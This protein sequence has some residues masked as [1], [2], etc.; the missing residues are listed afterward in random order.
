MIHISER[1]RETAEELSWQI[2][3]RS[4]SN[5]SLLSDPTTPFELFDLPDGQWGADP[6][7]F[8][9]D[10]QLCLFYELY[11]EK[12]KKGVI[13]VSKWEGNN[14]S[15][16]ETVIEEPFH[17]SFPC[18]FKIGESVYMIPKPAPKTR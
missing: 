18:V 5:G 16:P 15:Q 3:Y 11:L 17:L 13:A 10:G 6:F 4:K 1:W 14:F 9:Q 7:L 2:A 8:E 12:Q